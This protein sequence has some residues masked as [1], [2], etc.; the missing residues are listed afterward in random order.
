MGAGQCAGICRGY[1]V[2]EGALECVD[3]G[4]H[5]LGCQLFL[6]QHVLHGDKTIK[7]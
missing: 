7:P 4:G 5:G 3:M 2:V 6:G 1:V